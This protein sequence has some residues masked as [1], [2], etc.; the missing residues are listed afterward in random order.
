MMSGPGTRTVSQSA[1]RFLLSLLGTDL[2]DLTEV[3]EVTSSWSVRTSDPLMIVGWA[4][5]LER[6]LPLENNQI[7]ALQIDQIK[8]VE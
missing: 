3:T 2:T 6:S 7:S 8:H 5:A 4:L 1:S